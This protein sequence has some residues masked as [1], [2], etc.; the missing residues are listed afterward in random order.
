MGKI[1]DI[2]H[3]QGEIDWTKARTELD[4]AIFRTSVGSNPDKR[5]LSY[6][7]ECEVPYGAYHYVK[8]GTAEDARTEARF[9][10]ECADKAAKKPLFYIA[11]I[12]YEAQTETTTE[13]VCVAFLDELRKLVGNAKIGL[14]INRK[15][16]WAGKAIDM[17]DIMWIPHWGKNNGNV[18]ADKYKPDYPYDLWQYTSKGMLAGVE[19][20]VDLNQM[21]DGRTMDF[22]IGD[23]RANKELERSENPMFT[24]LQLVT[25]MLAVYAAKWVYWY[26]TCGYE[27]TKSLMKRKAEQYPKHYSADRTKGY[28][29]DIVAGKMCAD[30][31]GVIKSFFWK[32]G[33][34]NGK[35]VYQANNCPDRSAN[36]L[37]GMCE[38]T[39]KISTIPDIPGLVVWRSG[40]IGIYIGGGETIELKGFA[41]DCVRAKVTDGSWTNWGKLPTSMLAYV[42]AGNEISPADPVKLGDRL[43][44]EKGDKGE[45]VKELQAALKE[46]GYDLGTFGENKDGIDGDYG[47][48]TRDAVEALQR[49]SGLKE[50]GVFDASAYKA[51]LNELSKD[52]APAPD[53]DTP[54]GGSAPAHV[55]IIEGDEKKLRLVQ[56]AY[57]GTLAAVDSV[58]VV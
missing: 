51:L 41:Y 14:Y 48:K 12:E 52:E 58:M 38:E 33:D 1:A 36:G 44:L 46:L 24:N 43:P 57:G 22:F 53:V 47:N 20:D 2:S 21:G 27:C 18:P 26:G 42:D 13:P 23:E 25:Y 35:N 11:D 34:L 6:T 15:Y 32:G 28:E 29:A 56:G 37:Y 49:M 39:G 45:D 8:A 55:L 50:T 10:V 3:Y 19:G 16:K 9:F 40:H 7:A 4:F 31:V 5:Y 30:C 17:C 54:D